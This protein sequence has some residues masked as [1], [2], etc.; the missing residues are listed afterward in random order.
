[1]AA[2]AGADGGRGAI[3]ATGAPG[4]GA[5]GR[6]L[7]VCAEPGLGG[8]GREGFFCSSGLAPSSPAVDDKLKYHLRTYCGLYP[9]VNAPF[10]VFLP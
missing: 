7:A 9:P 1:M 8:V 4:L 2:A 6:E 10:P 3:G 5:G